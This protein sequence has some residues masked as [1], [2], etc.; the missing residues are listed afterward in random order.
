[1][2]ILGKGATSEEV[3]KMTLEL[4]KATLQNEEMKKKY[5]EL[6]IL[7]DNLESKFKIA[8]D[9]NKILTQKTNLIHQ[10]YTTLEL[11]CKKQNDKIS[12]YEGANKE[13]QFI[14]E[15]MEK[16]K[17]SAADLSGLSSLLG[18]K[19]ESLELQTI[20]DFQKAVNS[21]QITQKQKEILLAYAN[22]SQ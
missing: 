7:F 19:Q 18:Q 21:L 22:S 15:R 14:I 9:S 16:E 10:H 8:S 1:M 11:K 5:D 20:A 6:K 4:E 13:L 12:E 2:L 3:K 17:K